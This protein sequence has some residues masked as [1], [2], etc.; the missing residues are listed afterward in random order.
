MCHLAGLWAS[1][2]FASLLTGHGMHVLMDEQR[3]GNEK[4]ISSGGQ[5]LL[6]FDMIHSAKW[7][8]C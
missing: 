1:A 5:S 6:A 4:R 8:H 7:I 2:K 3:H